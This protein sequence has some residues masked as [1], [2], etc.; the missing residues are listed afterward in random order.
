LH[1][2]LAVAV[3]AVFTPT[4]PH[5]EACAQEVHGAFPV[6]ENVVPAAHATWHTVSEVLEQ[7]VFT[8]AVHVEEAAHV[9]HGAVPAVENVD[10]ATQA[11][12][13]LQQVASLG[14]VAPDLLLSYTRDPVHDASANAPPPLAVSPQVGMKAALQHVFR[15]VPLASQVGPAHGDVALDGS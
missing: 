15:S 9:E 1:T 4:A 6:V 10:P 11:A 14:L 5:A 2:V 8:P 3:H 12:A 7:A 13:F